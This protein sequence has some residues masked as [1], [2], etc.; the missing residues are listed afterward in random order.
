MLV[1]GEGERIPKTDRFK[2]EP[3]KII[4]IVQSKKIFIQVI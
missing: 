1:E 4:A 2:Y 3:E